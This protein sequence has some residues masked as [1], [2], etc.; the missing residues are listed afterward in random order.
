MIDTAEQTRLDTY[1]R[2]RDELF[3]E[4]YNKLRKYARARLQRLPPGQ[5]MQSTEI[6]HEVYIKLC[7]K[8]N[9]NWKTSGHFFWLAAYAVRD[10]IAER[11]RKKMS[12]RRGGKLQRSDISVSLLESRQP[13][14]M[15]ELLALFH[16]LDTLERADPG[17]AK[18][19]DLHCFAGCT[20]EEIARLQSV[21]SKTVQ[22][23]WRVA[24]A[25]LQGALGEQ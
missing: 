15:K 4:H 13:L 2:M 17:L 25:W 12:A 1:P 23:R 11:V 21:S 6:V 9:M 3:T 24:R 8:Q 22:R 5:T 19:V 10:V 7:K 20:F 18:L 16:A 14:N